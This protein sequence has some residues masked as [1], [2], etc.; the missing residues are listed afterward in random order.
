[1]DVKQKLLNNINLLGKYF[2]S[3]LKESWDIVDYPIQFKKTSNYR[4]DDQNRLEPVS[5]SARVINWWAMIGFGETKVKALE[6]LEDKFEE[7]KSSGQVLPRPG[8]K[9]PLNFAPTMVI[10]RYEPLA[11]DFFEKILDMNYYNCYVSD[12][13][14][15]GDFFMSGGIKVLQQKIEQVYGVDASD[16]KSG[17]LAEIFIRISNLQSKVAKET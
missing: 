8:T 14:S 13:T 9:A 12:Q 10:D 4:I 17:N 7:Y 5:W 1:M 6:D 11:V 2:S 3:F 15:L 16:I